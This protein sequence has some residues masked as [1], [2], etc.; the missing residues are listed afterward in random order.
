M[1]AA[2]QENVRAL[3]RRTTKRA[4]AEALGLCSGPGAYE[5]GEERWSPNPGRLND[6]HVGSFS[7]N[8]RTGAWH[9][10]ADNSSGDAFELI[11]RCTGERP[12]DVARRLDSASASNQ[13]AR[14]PKPSRADDWEPV[15]PIP[16]SME[17]PAFTVRTLGTPAHVFAYYCPDGAPHSFTA[18]YELEG[19]KQMRPWSTWR[20]RKTGETRFRMKRPPGP[21]PLYRGLEALRQPTAPRVL[22]EGEKKTDVA[23]AFF[24][25]AEAPHVALGLN[26]G[27]SAAKLNDFAAYAKS[28]EIW[29]LFPDKD[30][31]GVGAMETAAQILSALG[32][33]VF[34]VQPPDELP[35]GGDI[36]DLNNLGWSP[37]AILELVGRAEPWRSRL[38]AEQ[39]PDD[40]F[41]WAPSHGLAADLLFAELGGCW[42]FERFD[43][44]GRGEFFQK[45][46][47]Y[48]EPVLDARHRA[49]SILERQVTASFERL[50]A[51][52]GSE[53][54]RKIY[55]AMGKALQKIRT[56]DFLSASLALLAERLAL[57][58][59]PWNTTPEAL[60]TRTGVLDFSGPT[61]VVRDAR[62]DEYFCNPVPLKAE[63]IMAA[64]E[65][66][67]FDAF[68]ATLF[69]DS[70][71]QKSARHC[72]AACI[73]NRAQ[74]TFQIWWNKEGD[75]GKNSLMDLVHRLLP[76][77]TATLRGALILYKGDKSERR[78]GEIELRGRT[79]GFFDEVGG[80]FDVPAI[81]R[82]VSLSAIR[83]EAKGKDSVEFSPTWALVALCNT[84]PRFYPANDGGFLSRLFVLPFGSIFYASDEA[85]SRHISLGVD[86]KRLHPAKDKDLL[87]GELLGEHA[88]ILKSLIHHYIDLRDNYGGKPFESAVCRKAREEYR[89]SNDTAELFFRECLIRDDKGRIS[90][91]DL[92]ALYHAFAGSQKASTREVVKMVLGRFSFTEAKPSHGVRYVF[93]IRNSIPIPP[94]EKTQRQEEQNQE[95]VQDGEL[96]F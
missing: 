93:G 79:A 50:R 96:G 6:K 44:A 18:R 54:I 74:K 60:A 52:I 47:C 28:G 63:E 58:N 48:Y 83:A 36:A 13:P 37:A 86:P 25:D 4:I 64:G 62:P 30:R 1:S 49:R 21:L 31:P 72:I 71:T 91:E 43:S 34:I 77:R 24:R 15:V 32:C 7:I 22:F 67:V 80:V 35:E 10:F 55:E 8:M 66:V 40:S 69:P 27:A 68:I 81:K 11:A 39:P 3:F 5:Q 95:G 85:Y 2:T 57:V 23:A 61:P 75:A 90:Y 70:D 29:T 46:A 88:A 20:H 76:G 94:R 73:S 84:L 19:R 41:L 33:E 42:F 38:A 14:P 92:C 65:C 59:V 12:V 78:F 17:R 89:L 82:L 56:K 53:Q 16:A 45:V 87:L 51:S 9:D 26:G